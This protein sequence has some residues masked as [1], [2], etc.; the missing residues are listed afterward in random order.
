[1]KLNYK[2]IGDCIRLVDERNIDGSVKQLLGLSISKE[3][4][5]SVANIVGTNMKNYKV[6]RK[7]QFACSTMQVRRDKK[8]PIALYT[9]NDEAIISAAYP[10]FEVVDMEYI[11]PEYLMMWFRRT[12]F[13]REA[14]F[15][16]IGGVRGS[17]EWEDFCNMQLPVP[18]IAKQKEILKEYNVLVDRIN[19]NNR[20]IQKL[21]ETAQAI[22]KQWFVDF[23]FPDEN[24]NP[25]KTNG[26]EMKIEEETGMEIPKGWSNKVIGG[27]VSLSQGLVLNGKTNHLIKDKGIP[28]LRI[29]DLINNTQ[30]IFIDISVPEKNLV[31]EDE[32][33]ITRTGQVGLVF[34]NKKGVIHNNCF[35]ITPNPSLLNKDYLFWFLKKEST[36]CAMIEL[37]SGSAQLDLT[38]SSFSK[39]LITIPAINIQSLFSKVVTPIEHHKELVFNQNRRL[40]EL[41]RILLS[42]LTKVED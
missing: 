20:L 32:I 17:I 18:S 30:E 2:R 14:C 11:L 28:L 1:M 9:D 31:K 12:E 34:R 38:H 22:H 27:Y 41:K 19:L 4:I 37:A 15:H 36:R 29:K 25:Y 24:G 3:F 40:T 21:E 13:D 26:G 6:I 8:M 35:K 7:N 42:K 33:I 23:D 10:V 16:A 39:L 5:P